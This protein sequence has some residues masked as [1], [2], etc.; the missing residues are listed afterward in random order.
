MND[1]VCQSFRSLLKLGA[2]PMDDSTMPEIQLLLYS[3]GNFPWVV[4]VHPSYDVAIFVQWNWARSL[5]TVVALDRTCF[6]CHVLGGTGDR[7]TE[8]EKYWCTSQGVSIK[9]LSLG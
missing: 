9:A 6:A 4:V 5:D 2:V 1:F 7:G 8:D 3:Y